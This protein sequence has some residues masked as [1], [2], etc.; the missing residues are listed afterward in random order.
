MDLLIKTWAVLELDDDIMMA[1]DDVDRG[2]MVW[3]QYPNR[4]VGFYPRFVDGS[5]LEYRGEK[6]ARKN[7]GYNMIL[8]GLLS[9]IVK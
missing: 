7:K 5:R 6:Y 8:T 2:F 1:C 9:L 3:H 4:I